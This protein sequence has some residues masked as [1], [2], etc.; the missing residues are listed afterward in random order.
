MEAG[1]FAAA[2]A[3][4]FAEVDEEGGERAWARDGEPAEAAAAAGAT[5]STI[6]SSIVGVAV[7]LEFA[8]DPG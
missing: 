1:D 5:V 6:K 4:T 2:A 8:G 7:Y 3:A